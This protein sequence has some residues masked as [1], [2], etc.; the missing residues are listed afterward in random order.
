M[1]TD[2]TLISGNIVDVLQGKI[3]S[4]VLH[5]ENGKIIL[6]TKNSNVYSNYIIPG[7]I[8]SHV[9]IESSMLIPSE[10]A[11]LAAC[12]GTVATVSDPHEIGNVLG[13]NGVN[14]MINNA[15]KVPLKF[16]FG[17][18]SCVPA[19]PFE[20]A[21]VTMDVTQI[22]TMF[23]SE[24]I[25][26]LSEMMNVPGVLNNDPVV[27]EKIT[28]AQ[29]YG[30]KIDGHAPGLRGEDA[31]KYIN[32]GIS[33]DHECVSIEEALE[34][35]GYGI[36]IQIREGSAAKNFNELVPLIETHPDDCM[37]CSDDKHPDDLM[38]GH[39]NEMVKGALRLGFDKMKVLKCAS[40]NPVLHY[41]LD[42][43]LLQPGDP[44]DFI[45]IDN[46]KNFTVLKTYVNG[47]LI[48]ENGKSLI[49]SVN[50]E[51]INYFNAKEKH[52]EDFKI[53]PNGDKIKVI[54]VIDGQ[55]ITT[56]GY[57]TP[58]VLNDNLVSD[59][60][61]DILKITVV[62]RYQDAAPALG[63]VQNFGLKKGAI[64]SSV[65]HDSH[66]IVAVGTSDEMICN[67]VNLI[68]KNKGGIAAVSQEKCKIL[69]L[70]VAGIMSDEDGYKIALKY[71]ELDILAK[72][73][74]SK[75]NA[76]FMML[77]FMALLVI[78]EIK[79]SDKGLF[80]GTKFELTSLFV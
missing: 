35:I 37:F 71:S 23:Q 50:A 44:A 45:V 74:G 63:F 65:S 80:D 8:D 66:N 49:P 41:G 42:V 57:S 73:L 67:A 64:A 14:F 46:L 36:K 7:L 62:N 9:H 61:R 15:E 28:L 3:Y 76:P 51:Q 68:I 21:G 58:K 43:G 24:K 75:L 38:K 53:Q 31:Q 60:D 27:M 33:T 55:L 70:P 54:E 18:P 29:K 78:P 32:A 12:H 30:K 13:I 11:R 39:I 20:T 22:E 77:S 2:S 40:V 4:G 52:I 48:A 1:K 69:K 6:I 79:L 17:A 10:F 25:K 19:T 26:F 34:K 47:E 59:T 72:E 56:T 16:Y 5:I